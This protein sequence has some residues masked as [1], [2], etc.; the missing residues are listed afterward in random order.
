MET[1]FQDLPDEAF[2]LL[3]E[4]ADAASHA[5][6][7][8]PFDATEV[9][10]RVEASIYNWRNLLGQLDR[11]VHSPTLPIGRRTRNAA[12][13]ASMLRESRII[14]HQLQTF[15]LLL[16]G[17]AGDTAANELLREVGV[18]Q[19]TLVGILINDYRLPARI[20]LDPM[21][22]IATPAQPE[23]EVSGGI[24]AFGPATDAS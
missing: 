2:D 5:V 23:G 16:I 13:L 14:E 21:V 4:S 8:E 10:R 7:D 9:Y 17:A 1:R 18:L 20:D 22:L 19:R 24:S 15:G 12:R 6:M 3:F 11:E